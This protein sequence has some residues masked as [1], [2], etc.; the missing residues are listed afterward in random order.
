MH[1]RE[2]TMQAAEKLTDSRF[3]ALPHTLIHGDVQ[4]ANIIIEDSGRAVLVDLDW[5]AWRRASRLVFGLLMCCSH[6]AEPITGEDIWSLTQPGA[7]CR[8][9]AK[10]FWARIARRDGR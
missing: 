8:T 5:C 9:D 7:S 6:H 4:P 3:D 1:D 10:C 2:W